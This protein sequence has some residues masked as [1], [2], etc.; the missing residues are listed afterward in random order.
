MYRA[1]TGMNRSG[2]TPA[3][4]KSDSVTSSSLRSLRVP[5]STICDV[6]GPDPGRTVCQFVLL[7]YWKSLGAMESF[8]HPDVNGIGY[9]GRELKKDWWIKEVL[10]LFKKLEGAGARVNLGTFKMRDFERQSP[11]IWWVPDLENLRTGPVPGSNKS[12]QLKLLLYVENKIFRGKQR[13]SKSKIRWK[14]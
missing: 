12:W 4:G 14:R 13:S 5:H 1:R 6:V 9:C 8:K 2:A 10:E 3:H 7:V 11:L